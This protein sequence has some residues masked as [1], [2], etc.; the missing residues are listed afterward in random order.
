MEHTY[1]SY[2]FIHIENGGYS[3][4][5]IWGHLSKPIVKWGEEY[6]IKLR[7]NIVVN[8]MNGRDE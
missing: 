8:E 3:I 6:R 1:T 5:Y 4:N 2:L 7:M